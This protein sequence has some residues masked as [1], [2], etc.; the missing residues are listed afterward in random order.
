MTDTPCTDCHIPVPNGQ[1]VQRSV[2]LKRVVFC[3]P[4]AEDR[5]LIDPARP[6]L[7]VVR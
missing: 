5:N 7:Q 4:C 2:R 3:R 6:V 1:Q